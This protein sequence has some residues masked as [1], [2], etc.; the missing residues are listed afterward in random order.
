[1]CSGYAAKA[2]AAAEVKV[3]NGSFLE[4]GIKQP[5]GQITEHF[6]DQQLMQLDKQVQT[7][8]RVDQEQV[9]ELLD[10]VKRAG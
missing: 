5:N 6:V 8:G 4:K 3:Q 9:S 2:A 10:L 7:W 1:L